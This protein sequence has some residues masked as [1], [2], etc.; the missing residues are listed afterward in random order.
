MV[1]A[2]VLMAAGTSAAILP[3]MWNSND[4]DLQTGTWTEIYGTD[5]PGQPGAMLS[6]V[7]M[8]GM[9]WSLSGIEILSP[10]VGNDNGDG[11]ITYTTEYGNADPSVAV[12]ML[13]A[14]PGLW[15][16]AVTFTGLAITVEAT[17]DMNTGAYIGGTFTGSAASDLGLMIDIEGTLTETGELTDPAGH[18]GM[19]TYIEVTITGDA[20][21]P[22][23]IKPGSCPNAFNARSKGVLPMA[24]LGDEGFDVTMIDVESIRLKLADD[25]NAEG[26]APLMG[27]PGPGI[28][29]EDVA[30]PVDG[31]PCACAETY[32]DGY[33]D[34]TLKFRTQDV[35]G[36]GTFEAGTTVELL[37]TGTLTDGTPFVAS[38]CI[39]VV[40][41][42]K[43]VQV[44]TRVQ[45]RNAGLGQAVK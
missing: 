16:G 9:Q 3:G 24:L 7:S 45:A 40:Q 14:A 12:L 5:G 27:P 15:D 2:V 43:M 38:D 28:G 21:I 18:E 6:A 11:T 41:V 32:G 13:G 17:I 34:L 36:L 19:V 10:A 20:I 35:A 39:R 44:Q 1:M 4:S 8:D 25:P 31:E 30:T 23:D 42:A 37:I 26:I 29:Y 33:M 22:L